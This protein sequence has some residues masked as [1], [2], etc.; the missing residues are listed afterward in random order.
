[1]IKYS[2]DFILALVDSFVNITLKNFRIFIVWNQ[3]TL[4]PSRVIVALSG[5]LV[6]LTTLVFKVIGN[7]CQRY[8]FSIN[9][10]WNFGSGERL[11]ELVAVVRSWLSFGGFFLQLRWELY[12]TWLC[13]VLM[14]FRFD[15]LVAVNCFTFI[16]CRSICKPPRFALR[17]DDNLEKP[18]GS[19]KW[20]M[21]SSKWLFYFS[22]L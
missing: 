5:D 3:V 18:S 13:I 2:C 20:C 6:S 14:V 16:S 1:M 10:C 17:W 8:Y 19:I 7:N 4:A 15:G 9:S 11:M 12:G 22:L 21:N